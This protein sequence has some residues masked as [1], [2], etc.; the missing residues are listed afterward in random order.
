MGWSPQSSGSDT[1]SSAAAEPA[2][3]SPS[4]VANEEV[5]PLPALIEAFSLEGVNKNRATM[6]AAKLDFLNRAHLRIKLADM[7]EGGGR[8]DVAIRA[9]KVIIEK[10]PQL[11]EQR[12]EVVSETYIANVAEALKVRCRFRHQEQAR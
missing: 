6:Q 12:P 10:W 11:E 5:L 1:P 9:R 2:S 7:T 4:D 8:H 3:S